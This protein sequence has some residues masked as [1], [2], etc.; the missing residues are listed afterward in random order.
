VNGSAAGIVATTGSRPG[1]VRIS[2]SD[3]ELRLFPLSAGRKRFSDSVVEFG[4]VTS[5]KTMDGA[6]G[7]DGARSRIAGNGSGLGSGS[8]GISTLGVWG[9]LGIG[10]ITGSTSTFGN[11]GIG[12]GLTW[13]GE[14]PAIPARPIVAMVRFRAIADSPPGMDNRP[15][16]QV[17]P[18]TG[19]FRFDGPPTTDAN[20]TGHVTS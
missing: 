13:A 10:P 12:N 20:N 15:G 6:V 16:R 8:T 11:S 7:A 4:F 14:S 5:G 1:V 19:P 3:P 18:P 9:P 17:S 2:R